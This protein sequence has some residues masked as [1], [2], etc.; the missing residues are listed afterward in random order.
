MVPPCRLTGESSISSTRSK[1]QSRLRTSATMARSPTAALCKDRPQR[2]PSRWADDR[3]QRLSLD[4]ALRGLAGAALFALENSSSKSAFPS[5]TSPRSHSEERVCVPLLPRLRA[6]CSSPMTSLSNPR[7]ETSSSFASTCL[8]CHA[9]S[10]A[11]DLLRP[12]ACV[13]R[14]RSPDDRP[15]IRRPCGYPTRQ[16][17]HLQRDCL[18]WRTAQR[19][20]CG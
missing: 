20:S 6:S 13:E 16:A 14:S 18:T 15:S 3:Q 1:A 2:R 11:T 10:S 17:D 5:R 4:F 9:P 19:R 12:A 8:E 7:L